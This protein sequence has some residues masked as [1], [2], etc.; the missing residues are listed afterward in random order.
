MM[1]E[2]LNEHL[3]GE[4]SLFQTSGLRIVNTVFE[5]GESP[6]KHSRYIEIEKSRFNGMY[7]LWYSERI[8][9]TD[10]EISEN[11]VA[12]VWYASEVTVNDTTINAPKCF[13]RCHGVSLRNVTFTN[14]DDSFWKCQNIR[15]SN[16]KVMGEYFCMDSD[17]MEITALD[18]KG[19]FA[20][21]SARNLTLRGS[22]ITSRDAFWNCENIVVYDSKI[23]SECL[24]WNSRNITFVNCTIE[25]HQGMCFVKNLV[26][27]KCTLPNTDLAF[28]YSN[29]NAEIIGNI[30][31]V[32]NP[33]GG[34][35]K[36]DS[37]GE[38]ILEI[39]N[40]DVS[41]TKIICGE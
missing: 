15:L 36:A 32:K 4:R 34:L 40:V 12:A 16:V 23:T 41:R 24:G 21:E 33:A 17:G 30:D 26:L 31:S 29:V 10:S 39:E 20:F 6:L 13:R 5:N 9:L 1:K 3:T 35:I 2:I 28:E 27:K 8:K 18:L 14:G 7:P 38:T 11:G 22:V 25:S 19:D 37:I